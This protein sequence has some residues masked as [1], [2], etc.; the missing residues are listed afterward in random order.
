MRIN[1]LLWQRCPLFYDDEDS[2]GG[3]QKLQCT[4]ERALF[5]SHRR[6][7]G[8]N[9]IYSGQVVTLVRGISLS[10]R[11]CHTELWAVH[12]G[13]VTGDNTSTEW[14]KSHA[15]H[16]WHMFYLSKNKL[17][18]NQKKKTMLYYVLEM[19][20]AF[21]DACIHSFPHVWCNPVKFLQW[22]KRFTRRDIVDLC[23]TGESGNVSLNSFWQVK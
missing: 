4:T 22:R 9:A 23:G 13:T 20:T 14:S 3:S 12:C 6:G 2:V 8:G 18:L 11:L 17:H 16:Y 5:N 1:S 19:S 15:T 7:T 10:R 21:S